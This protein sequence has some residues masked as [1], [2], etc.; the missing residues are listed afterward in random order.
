MEQLRLLAVLSD[1]AAVAQGG[2]HVK[3]SGTSCSLKTLPGTWSAQALACL[4]HVGMKRLMPDQHSGLG[5]GAEYK[6]AERL[7][8]GG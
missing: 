2:L 5:I 8:R 1:V 3:G 7:H 6:E 4:I